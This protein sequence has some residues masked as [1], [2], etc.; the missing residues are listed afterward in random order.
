VYDIASNT[1]DLSHPNMPVGVHHTACIVYKNELWVLGGRPDGINGKDG[2]QHTQIYN[3]LTKVWRTSATDPSIPHYPYAVA[4]TGPAV[5]YDGE[6]YIFGGGC[7][8]SKFTNANS[9]FNETRILNP[10]T[11]VWRYGPNMLT[12]REAISPVLWAEKS[13]IYVVTSS[14]AMAWDFTG[15]NEALILDGANGTNS[16]TTN[17]GD[18]PANIHTNDKSAAISATARVYSMLMALIAIVLLVL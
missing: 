13:K 9:I 10:V 7:K 1:W 15:F 18:K 2:S 6:F 14:R 17:P 11:G 12:P 8:H 5:M 4:G 16:E 3:H